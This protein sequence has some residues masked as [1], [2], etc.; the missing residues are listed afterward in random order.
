MAPKKVKK[1]LAF[2]LIE[3]STGMKPN[4]FLKL[5]R[6]LPANQKNKLI[7]Q[8]N[9]NDAIRM[10]SEKTDDELDYMKNFLMSNKFVNQRVALRQHYQTHAGLKRFTTKLK[11]AFD[12]AQALPKLKGGRSAPAEI[13]RN[14]IE[15]FAL[16]YNT[17]NPFLNKQIKNI[18]GENN[19]TSLQRRGQT[20]GLINKNTIKFN[21][22]IAGAVL[23]SGPMFDQATM[24][25]ANILKRYKEL[26]P[27]TSGSELRLGTYNF[28]YIDTIKLF[29]T[30]PFLKAYIN[31]PSRQGGSTTGAI[32][33]DQVKGA[34][35]IIKRRKNK[36]LKALKELGVLDELN[37]SSINLTSG[38]PR[39][40]LTDNPKVKAFIID[41]AKKGNP[42]L[43]GSN[44]TKILE[45]DQKFYF[46][47]FLKRFRKN[48]YDSGLDTTPLMREF[49]ET[50]N[51]ANRAT[52]LIRSNFNRYMRF[53]LIEGKDVNE[54]FDG[55]KKQV[56]SKDFM[57]KAMP[58]FY[59]TERL[60][61][62]IKYNFSK[63]GIE[64]PEVS[65]SHQSR[66]IDHIDKAFKANNI[67]TGFRKLNA[68]EQALQSQITALKSKIQQRG[69]AKL[70]QSD[71][72]V[73]NLQK[74]LND[75]EYQL[76]SGGYYE[77]VP[78]DFDAKMDQAVTDISTAGSFLFKDGGFAS[79][80]DVLDYRNG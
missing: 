43:V 3:Q 23:D 28:G 46:D 4:D 37:L 60:R 78:K 11:K 24:R 48:M 79:I 77:P 36:I 68:E 25:A 27:L 52:D 64:F 10:L 73:R 22:D 45:D 2:F 19:F 26:V 7:T 53:G 58:I 54:L 40:N 63:Y 49:G 21:Q 42:N 50:N 61:D 69:G 30:D 55:F 76:E 47:E 18:I 9:I 35:D 5:F 38:P 59:E 56:E 74:E 44:M 57:K 72:T 14:D 1:D 16:L 65:L 13:S 31:A 12:E 15:K 32:F 62:K 39:V 8:D 34:E 6:K 41:E 51:H 29:E 66:V 67:F 70:V 75:L 80:E 20:L 33:T 71:E 17:K